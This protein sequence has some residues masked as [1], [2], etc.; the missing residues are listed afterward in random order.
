MHD[1][2]L[3]KDKFP[4]KEIQERHAEGISGRV[5]IA[6]RGRIVGGIGEKLLTN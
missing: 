4:E 3:Q 5:G 6:G 2:E 1:E